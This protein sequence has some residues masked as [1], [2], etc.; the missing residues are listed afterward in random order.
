V[1]LV[2]AVLVASSVSSVASARASD[3]FAHAD[4]CLT[5]PNV[6]EFGVVIVGTAGDDLVDCSRSTIGHIVLGGNGDDRLIGSSTAPDAFDPGSGV[7]TVVG[8]EG[9][10]DVVYF[11]FAPAPV[12]ASVRGATN[13]GFGFD[14]SG[15]YEGIEDLWGSRFD[16]RLTGDDGPNGLHGGDGDDVLEGRGGDDLLDGGPGVDVAG[17]AD[18]L[19]GVVV[20]LSTGTARRAG[21]DHLVWI[22]GVDGSS[23]DDVI[24]GSAGPDVLSGRGGTD[25]LRGLDGDDVLNGGADPDTLIGGP[26]A[27]ALDGGAGV[28]GCLEG[29]GA[30]SKTACELEAY[31][32]VAGLALFVPS[33]DLIGLGFH[34]SLFPTA[35]AARPTGPLVVNGSA[36]HFTP[37][38]PIDGV[39]YDVMAS[40]GRGTPATTAADIVVPSQSTVLAPING[41]VV[42]VR[43]YLLYC[44]TTDWQIII[45][46]DGGPDLLVMVLHIVDV[47][48]RAGDRVVAGVT[49]IATSWGNDA[50]TAQENVYFPEQYPHVHVEVE[51]ADEAPI[52][53]CALS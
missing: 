14:E 36:S 2:A 7:D 48:V 30:G 15:R 38:S 31:A 34:E 42:L 8:G 29:T 50:P 41:T 24:T 6:Q 33:K 35:L 16:D 47:R 3:E 5:G 1:L 18:S 25:L 53:G 17:F 37:P 51:R 40:R 49:P 13:D 23:H 39:P 32:E 10:G 4:G 19:R 28:D 12:N 52:P 27:D 45:R 46:P 22:E 21:H 44:E 43:T 26:G 20:D 11:T 9:A